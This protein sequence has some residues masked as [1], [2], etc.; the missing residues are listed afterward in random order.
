LR[1]RGDIKVVEEPLVVGA[2]NGRPPEH[3][4][5]GR[6]RVVAFPARHGAITDANPFSDRDLVEFS[7]DTRQL[8]AGSEVSRSIQHRVHGSRIVHYSLSFRANRRNLRKI[9]HIDAQVM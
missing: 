8:E 1:R 4:M 5:H 7:C 3:L 9:H 6:G 2:D